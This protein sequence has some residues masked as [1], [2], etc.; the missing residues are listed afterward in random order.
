MRNEI[1]YDI[2]GIG[3]GPFNLGLA[4]LSEPLKDI[5]TI[6]IEQKPEF[7]WHEGM[8]IPGTT[9]QVSY[10]ADLV[11]LADPSSK[12]SYLNYL[13]K[14]NRLLQFGI[15]EKSY[16]TRSEYNRYCRWVCTQ[17]N[18]LQFG[19]CVKMIAYN[20]A[21]NYFEIK[22][23]NT[24][25][26]KTDTILAKHIVVGAGTR[27]AIPE[28]FDDYLGEN[29]IHSSSYLYYKDDIMRA[30]NIAVV[31]SGQSAAEIFF[32]L[33]NSV[34]SSST[35]L[36]W[37][38]KSD[39][40]Y[41][42]EHTKLNYEM[43]SPDYIDFFYGLDRE[44]KEQL[45]KNQFSLYKGINHQLIDAIYDKLYYMHMEEQKQQVAIHPHVELTGIIKRADNEYALTFYH[46][47]AKK[48]FGVLS[49]FVI[50][51]TGY[52]Y[53]FPH[54]LRQLKNLIQFDQ[55][56]NYKVN[57]NYSIDDADRLFVQ[58]A[59]M[60]THG[61]NTPDL[62]LGAYRNAV[63]INSILGGKTYPIDEATCFQT[64]GVAV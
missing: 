23:K 24:V 22:M 53:G 64:F 51:A 39:R 43:T 5:K 30:K 2:A 35:R 18:N 57:R 17:L 59:E 19:C 62:G 50:L 10:L 26:N 63:I 15:H 20:T 12:F 36:N 40:F 7:S 13:R 55:S 3:I 6:F 32:D 58:N 9:L 14:S 44:V 46:N 49:D 33:L 38:T 42:M 61:F 28:R 37:L 56:G 1:I 11:T 31:G 34:N 27:P 29:V 45:L 4:A 21:H 48:N 25:D 60:H 54:F 47:A 16:I 41:A 8:M 52:Q